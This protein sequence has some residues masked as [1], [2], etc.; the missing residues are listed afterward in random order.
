MNPMTILYVW[1]AASI[2]MFIGW[3]IQLR[4]RNIG[5]VDA[6]WAAC[7]GAAA[8]FYAWVG[9]GGL[10][11]RLAV[12][13]LGG[14]WALRLCLHILARVLGES[15]DGRYRYLREYWNGDQRK[16]LGFFMTQGLLTVLFS[17][18]FLA[19]AE[20]PRETFSIWCACGLTIW[21]ISIAG[22]SIADAQL[23]AFRKNPQNHGHTCRNG[24]WRYSR[25]PNYFFEWLHWFAYIFLAVGTPFPAWLLS[26]LGPTLMLAS[27][28]WIT[29][30]PFTEAQALRSRGDDYR[31]YQRSTSILIPWFP[32]ESGS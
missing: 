21:A 8:L 25:H 2:A 11:S 14:I 1:I 15:E 26:W 5:I 9:S 32:K 16:L 6:I 22:E 30:I 20:N 29:G 31:D 27:L 18:P 24:L 17:L 3:L 10:V 7:M 12:A 13:M 28:V 19:V 23:S 4:T